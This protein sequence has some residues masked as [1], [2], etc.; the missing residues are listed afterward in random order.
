MII[1]NVS[2]FRLFGFWSSV[3]EASVALASLSHNVSSVPIPGGRSLDPV[4][5]KGVDLIRL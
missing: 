4:K 5:N 3:S 1:Q 2:I